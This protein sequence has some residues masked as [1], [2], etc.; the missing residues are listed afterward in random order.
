MSSTDVEVREYEE[1]VQPL[2][3]VLVRT[4]DID[5]IAV[6]VADLRAH[7][8]RLND[9]I[10]QFDAAAVAWSKMLGKKTIAAAS[11]T[12]TVSADHEIEWDVEALE[13][14]RELGLPDARFDALVRMVVTYKVNASV[15]REIEGA[16]PEYA[17]VIRRARVRVPK[18]Q[19]VSVK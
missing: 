19:Y 1:I 13:E 2:T 15:A 9:A 16:S 18:R 3:G 7:R 12:L 8:A 5:A 14:L 11:H 17:E 6:A 4:D 10:S